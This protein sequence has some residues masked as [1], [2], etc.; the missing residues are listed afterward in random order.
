MSV[1][2]DGLLEWGGIKGAPRAKYWCHLFADS[3]PELHQFAQGIMLRKE[4]FQIS[5]AGIPHYDLTKSRRKMAV[6]HG[7]IEFTPTLADLV[8]FKAT[9]QETN[10]ERTQP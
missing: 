3:L 7:A 9:L 1:Y 6:E 2:V 10:D 4:W 5:N 8:R